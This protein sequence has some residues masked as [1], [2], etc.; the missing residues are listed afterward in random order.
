MLSLLLFGFSFFRLLSKSI[1]C[2]NACNNTD[3]KNEIDERK[4]IN[5]LYFFL[6]AAIPTEFT[7]CFGPYSP[8]AAA[9]A[10]MHY[11]FGAGYPPAPHG[12]SPKIQ[13]IFFAIIYFFRYLWIIRSNVTISKSN[14][15]DVSRWLS[16]II[17]SK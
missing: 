9:A 7:D 12:K 17:K 5:N 10:A 14:D 15:D 2:T 16:R 6:I 8:D 4:F 13:I 11:Q 1:I 3:D